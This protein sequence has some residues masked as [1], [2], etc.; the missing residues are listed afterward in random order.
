MKFHIIFIAIVI[1]IV[2]AA[3]YVGF[4]GVFRVRALG[5]LLG[6]FGFLFTFMLTD[7]ICDGIR[8]FGVGLIAIAIGLMLIWV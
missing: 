6:F 2:W 3:V 8:S 5:V 7:E 4:I 1:A